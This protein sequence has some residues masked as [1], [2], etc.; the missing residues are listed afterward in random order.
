MVKQF[1]K[2]QIKTVPSHSISK[3][4]LSPMCKVEFY[5]TPRLLFRLESKPVSYSVVFFLGWTNIYLANFGS[6]HLSLKNC[7]D[8]LIIKIGRGCPKESLMISSMCL[9]FLNMGSF[10][11]LDKYKTLAR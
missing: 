5:D 1:A 3:F 2:Y 9:Y 6:Y 7:R 4:A 10:G 11:S 8:D